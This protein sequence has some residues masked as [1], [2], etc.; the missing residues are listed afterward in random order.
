MRI[1][2]ALL[3]VAAT[4][5]AGSAIAAPAMAQDYRHGYERGYDQGYAPAYGYRAHY[6]APRHEWRR[7]WDHRHY[8]YRPWG[9]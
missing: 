1:C 8:G 6:Y 5:V 9:R 7:G 2:N 4:L 3:A